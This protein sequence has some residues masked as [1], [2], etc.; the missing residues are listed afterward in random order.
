MET[1][2]FFVVLQ[3]QELGTKSLVG[4]LLQKQRFGNEEFSRGFTKTGVGHEEFGRH[5]VKAEDWERRIFS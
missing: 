5:F 1:Q 2:N 3:K 4:I